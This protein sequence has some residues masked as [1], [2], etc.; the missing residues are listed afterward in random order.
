M[1]DEEVDELVRTALDSCGTRRRWGEYT[2]VAAL[3]HLDT[4]GISR[5]VLLH[6]DFS[7]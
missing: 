7:W 1:M 5:P 2:T 6:V 4:P 3:V